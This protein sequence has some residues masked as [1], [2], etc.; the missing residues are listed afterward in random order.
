MKITATSTVKLKTP[1]TI[2]KRFCKDDKVGQFLAEEWGKIF[3]KYVP[4]DTGT[5]SQS[6]TTKPFEVSYNQIYSHYQWNGISK[7]GNP[8]NYNKEKHPLAQSH[9]EKAAERDYADIIA[10]SVSEFIRRM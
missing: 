2:T 6:Y 5:L 3:R 10:D 8:L 7:N 4:M 9:W 1:A